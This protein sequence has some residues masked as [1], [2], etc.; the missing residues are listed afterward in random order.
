MPEGRER[1][2][3]PTPYERFEYHAA[4]LEEMDRE[5]API[6]AAFMAG[7]ISHRKLRKLLQATVN[8][9]IARP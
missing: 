5:T 4:L 7:K 9:Y 6:H 3:S 1:P 8:R 2:V